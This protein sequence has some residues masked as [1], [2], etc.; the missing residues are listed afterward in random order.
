MPDKAILHGKLKSKQCRCCYFTSLDKKVLKRHME[1]HLTEKTV[2]CSSAGCPEMFF[3]YSNMRYHFRIKHQNIKATAKEEPRTYTCE[4]CNAWYV[5]KR[6]FYNH[7]KEFNHQMGDLMI[8]QYCQKEFYKT[9][10]D[11]HLMLHCRVYNL[12]RYNKSKTQN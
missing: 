11:M 3:T 12:S 4:Q 1:T 8:C 7:L 6:K 9:G 10:L 2:Q 5:N